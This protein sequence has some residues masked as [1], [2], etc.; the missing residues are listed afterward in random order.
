MVGIR[1]SR[2]SEAD[3]S[4][5]RFERELQRLLLASGVARNVILSRDFDR[6]DVDVILE[7]TSL[8]LAE[9]YSINPFGLI[10]VVGTALLYLYLGGPFLYHFESLEVDLI[11][12]SP[13]GRDLF[14]VSHGDWYAHSFGI[15]SDHGRDRC[16]K[17]EIDKLMRPFFSDLQEALR[18]VPT[19]ASISLAY[20]FHGRLPDLESAKPP[21]EDEEPGGRGQ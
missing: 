19:G 2:S 13:D 1:A 12:R 10:P 9:T 16:P 5:L 6:G 15:R 21:R 18:K 14:N 17:S 3:K 4:R 11:G 7:I 20:G 8:D